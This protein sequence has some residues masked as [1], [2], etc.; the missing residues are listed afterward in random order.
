[1]V[2]LVDRRRRAARAVV[3]PRAAEHPLVQALAT[4]AEAGPQPVAGAG[5]VAVERDR[6]TGDHACH[7]ATY[8]CGS[9]MV[10]EFPAGSR[11][12]NIGGTGSPQCTISS[13]TSTPAAFSAAWSASMSVVEMTIPV[14]TAVGP[15]SIGG[16]IASAVEPPAGTTSI[17]RIFPSANVSSERNSKPSVST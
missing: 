1:E 4:L 3:G 14:S 11:S 5:D 17:Q 12:L 8:R 7:R 10:S 2:F 16:A 13:S 15:P 6:D 9:A